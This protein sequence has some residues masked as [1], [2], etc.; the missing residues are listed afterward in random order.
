MYIRVHVFYLLKTKLVCI[1]VTD[2]GGLK[3][4]TAEAQVFLTSRTCTFN[5]ITILIMALAQHNFA[6]FRCSVPRNF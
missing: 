1:I 3:F 5:S 4:K 2:V 6:C